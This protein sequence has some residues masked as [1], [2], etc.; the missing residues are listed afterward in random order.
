M[1]SR[2]LVPNQLPPLADVVDDSDRAPPSS[3][4]APA[5][6]SDALRAADHASACGMLAPAVG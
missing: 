2:Y 3:L 6:R 4:R 1:L 5:T